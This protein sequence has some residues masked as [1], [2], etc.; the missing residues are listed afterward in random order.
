MKKIYQIIIAIILLSGSLFTSCTLDEWNPS[1]VD[2]E[3]A[4]KYKNGYESLINYCYDGLYYFYGKI[5]GIGAMEMGTDSWVNTGSGENGF[6]LYD[7]NMN[8]TLGT[9]RTIWQGFYSTI[10]YCNTAIYYAEIVEGYSDA[11]LQA[12]VAEVYFLRAW[13]NW[14]LVEQ[15]GG[16]VL[17]TQPS[18]ITGVDNSPVRNS[19]EEFYDSIISDLQYACENLPVSQGVERGRV[20]KKAAYAMLAKACLQRTRLGE[21]E[22]YAKMALDA[23]EEL[24]N[25]QGKY[26]IALYTSDANQSGFAKLWSSEN[27]K[28]NAEFLFLE[29]IDH[30]EGKNPDS[31]NRGRT[32]QYYVMDCR[33]V[34]AVWGTQE[35]DAWLS[36]ANTRNFKPSKYLLT[37][38]FPP[39]KNSADTRFAETFFYEYYNANSSWSNLTI[40]ANMVNTYHK[41]SNLTGH[42]IPNTAGTIQTLARGGKGVNCMGVVNM[43]DDD[44]DGYL[45]GLSIYTPNWTVPVDEKRDLPFWVVDP[46]DMFDASGKWIT[47]ETNPAMGT[48]FKEI[49]PS[50]KK[51]SCLQYVDDRQQ[52]LGDIP[53]IRLGEV[54]LIA[55]E[56]ALLYNNDQPTALKYVNEIRKRAAVT[57]RQ[58]EI[59]A[60]Q[61]EM[62]LDYILAERGRE[63]CGEQ[64][65]W[66][67]LKRMGKLTSQYL[68]STNPDIL[69]FDESKHKIR[70]I[71]QSYL[72]AIS[73]P[74][75]FGNNG[76]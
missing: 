32:R 29:A 68:T 23:A 16:V 69:F 3:T 45:D 51:F 70:P 25:N 46:S 63:M 59:V 4:Y 71:P 5:D 2:L 19:E 66:Y 38:L 24:I 33:T 62:T 43:V 48:Y 1:T 49:Y 65:R 75:E 58:N 28:N 36:R 20:S 13:S 31:F 39:V 10:N 67:D 64:V 61:G 18:T 21:K 41:N 12:K 9:L 22:K 57:G 7:N 44:G 55:A 30:I 54:Y 26:S 76:Y 53:I 6:L 17:K 11:E 73:N 50:L 14:H 15:F 47:V 60:T 42:I 8:S 72:D 74:D 34:G 37:S 27:N 52:W 56:A 35:S 40:T